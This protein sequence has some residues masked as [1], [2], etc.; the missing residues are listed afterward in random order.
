MNGE[1][2]RARRIAVLFFA[3]V[4]AGALRAPSATA[5]DEPKAAK[6]VVV[7]VLD[8]EGRPV[9]RATLVV[10]DIRRRA[11]R[12]SVVDGRATLSEVGPETAISVFGAC[13][14]DGAALPLG[15]VEERALPAGDSEVEVRLAAGA[16]I[17]GLVTLPGD[18]PAAGVEVSAQR[19][20]WS[21]RVVRTAADG[22]FRLVGLGAGEYTIEVEAPAGSGKPARP[23][24]H[25]GDLDVRIHLAPA[26]APTLVVRDPEGKPVAS[27]RVGARRIPHSD[28]GPDASGTTDAAGVVRLDG[29]EQGAEYNLEL[30]APRERKDLA[31][32]ERS[33]WKPASETLTLPRG[34]TAKGVVLG[35]DGK[36]TEAM[37]WWSSGSNRTGRSTGPDGTFAI[38]HLPDGPISLLAT[39]Q[40]GSSF[41]AGEWTQVTPDRAEVV[42]RLGAD[43]RRSLVVR[44]VDS[45]GAPVN[46]AEALWQGADPLDMDFQGFAVRAGRGVIHVRGAGRLSVYRATAGDDRIL[47]LAP[48]VRQVASD[49]VEVEVRLTPGM[50][51]EGRVV[52][53]EGR[54]VAGVRVQATP[55]GAIYP[56]EVHGEA[57]SGADGSFRILSVGAGAYGLATAGVPSPFVPPPAVAATGGETGVQILLRSGTTVVLTVVDWSDGPVPGAQVTVIAAQGADEFGGDVF[58][59]GVTDSKGTVTLPRVDLRGKFS[60]I[61]TPPSDRDDLAGSVVPKPWEPSAAARF[62]FERGYVVTGTVRD[63]SGAPVSAAIFRGSPTGAEF[64]GRSAADGTFKLRG[65]PYGPALLRVQ[66]DPRAPGSR[67]WVEVTPENPKAD[68]RVERTK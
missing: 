26:I 64:A 20:A 4:L 18:A 5:G 23:A 14:A 8:T 13:S 21:H 31:D 10:T 44:V 54:S 29:L 6:V 43:G 67:D 22:T 41:H 48:S 68:L 34:F 40:D 52:D 50:R 27:V 39:A 38:E 36:P 24:A 62:R 63:G 1:I 3:G 28:G 57:V 12:E 19:D 47:P 66:G 65:V 33:P 53:E 55:E 37:V 7:R 16:E 30:T 35:A 45:D 15:T 11:H 59:E 2:A 25:G 58:F 51:I 60:L 46:R 42:L 9:P 61:V 56:D 49:A 17:R 32:L